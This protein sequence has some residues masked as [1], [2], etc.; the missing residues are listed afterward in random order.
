VYFA[1]AQRVA[2]VPK[3]A[4]WKKSEDYSPK[5]NLFPGCAAAVVVAASSDGTPPHLA[6]KRWGLVASY[7][8]A[9][10][11]DFWRMFNAR[12]ETLHTSPVFRRLLRSKRCAIPFDGFWEWTDDEMKAMAK[13]GKQPWYVHRTDA[14]PLW[15]A[16]LYDEQAATGLETFTVITMDVHKKL[17]WLHDVRA[18]APHIHAHTHIHAVRSPNASCAPR[19]RSACRCSSTQPALQNGSLRPRAATRRL[20]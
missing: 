16:G 13:A 19:R 4:S 17:A 18:R 5:E 20:R 11:P 3:D 6:T 1:A 2:G 14:E 10:K 12:S 8:K 7:D 9:E 15:M